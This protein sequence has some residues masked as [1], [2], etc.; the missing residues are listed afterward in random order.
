MNSIAFGEGGRRLLSLP[1]V[2]GE[3][4]LRALND[5]GMRIFACSR[6]QLTD[7]IKI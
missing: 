1:A 2:V 6:R 7:N 5:G 4:G 3:K